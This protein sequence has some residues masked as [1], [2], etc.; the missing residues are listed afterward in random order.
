MEYTDRMKSNAPEKKD[1]LRRKSNISGQ[2][3]LASLLE[4]YRNFWRCKLQNDWSDRNVVQQGIIFVQRK[5]LGTK[6]ME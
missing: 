2:H 4:I 3:E 1:K 6:K 5:G